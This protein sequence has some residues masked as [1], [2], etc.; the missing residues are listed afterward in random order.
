MAKEKSV[1]LDFIS[2]ILDD[3]SIILKI[4]AMT[5]NTDINERIARHI[6]ELRTAKG[7]SLDVL[8]ARSGV[9]RSTI[10]LIE[11]AATSPTAVVLEKL[12]AGLDVSLA[13]LFSYEAEGTAIQPL[14]HQAQQLQWRDPE[15]GYI[16]R[17]LSP[18]GWKSPIQ[19]VEVNFP[20]H[21]RVAYD[22]TGR[23]KPVYQQIWMLNGTMNILF[24]SETYVLNQGDCLALKLDQP[25]IF[26]NLT[27]NSARYIV[28]ICD[29]SI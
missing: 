6:R 11:R 13:S 27:S 25:L 3:I 18:P 10:S 5:E 17:N 29:G 20:A 26:H 15:T 28:A 16:R 2:S 14:V 4:A 1:S 24:G 9:S 8:A 12:A 22:L 7:Y 23:E 19:L 21:T